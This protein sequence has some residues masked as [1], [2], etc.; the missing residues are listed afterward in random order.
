MTPAMSSVPPEVG[1]P[2]RVAGRAWLESLLWGMTLTTLYG[3]V[4]LA[5]WTALASAING[6]LMSEWTTVLAFLAIGL[7]VLGFA[8]PLYGAM[9]GA[10]SGMAIGASLGLL[11]SIAS[12]RGGVAS[13]ATRAIGAASAFLSVAGL[14]GLGAAA[15]AAGDKGQLLTEVRGPELWDVVFFSVPPGLIAAAVFAWRSPKILQAGTGAV[16]PGAGSRTL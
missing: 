15:W 8:G 11:A 13:S 10:A 7:L 6:T 16:A 4:V 14:L 3:A 5:G 2:R 1:T 9:L 12:R